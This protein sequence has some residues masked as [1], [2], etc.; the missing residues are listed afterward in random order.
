[1]D[2]VLDILLHSEAVLVKKIKGL[3]DGKPKW[4]ANE[5]MTELREAIRVLSTYGDIDTQCIA[6]GNYIMINPTTGLDMDQKYDDFLANGGR[7][8]SDNIK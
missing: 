7:K 1:M 8:A 5:Q 3:K 4:A 6:F 2:Y